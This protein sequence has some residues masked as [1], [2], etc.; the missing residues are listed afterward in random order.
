MIILIVIALIVLGYLG[1][2]VRTI[3]NSEPVQKNLQYGKELALTIWYSYL[4]KP[5]LY[6]WNNIFLD[7][8]WTTFVDNMERIKAGQPTTLNI[9]SPQLPQIQN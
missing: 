6:F 2:D 7:L 3:I 1:Y 4:E 5:A 8:L 9:N